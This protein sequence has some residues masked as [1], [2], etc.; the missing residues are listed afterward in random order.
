MRRA[1]ALALGLLV[2]VALAPARAGADTAQGPYHWYLENSGALFGALFGGPSVSQARNGTQLEAEGTGG[3]FVGRKA[4]SVN[5]GGTYRLLNSNGN[6]IGKGNF[7]VRGPV[8]FE[9]QGPL[10]EGPNA[11]FSLLTDYR[12]GVMVAVADFGKLG[13]GKITIYCDAG[14]QGLEGFQL[15]LRRLNFDKIVAGSTDFV[16]SDD[17]SMPGRF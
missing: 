1:L 7:E 5:G 12:R 8:R 15:K 17:S 16:K 9:D 13:V 2:G 11:I 4:T 14:S 3:F 10:N 6:E